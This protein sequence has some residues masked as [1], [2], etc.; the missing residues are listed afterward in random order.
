MPRMRPTR[1]DTSPRREPAQCIRELDHR[2]VPHRGPVGSRRQAPP[3]PRRRAVRDGG[4]REAAAR[5]RGP[6]PRAESKGGLP[7]GAPLLRARPPADRSVRS[8]ARLGRERG[9]RAARG[10]ILPHRPGRA[11]H[12][13]CSAPGALSRRAHPRHGE[14]FRVPRAGLRRGAKAARELTEMER[15]STYAMRPSSRFA[16]CLCTLLLATTWI[17]CAAVQ[18]PGETKADAVLKADVAAALKQWELAY[19]C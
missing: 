13:A 3:R 14:P 5:D 19:G 10:E 6:Y 18:V 17:G 7:S 8:T 1:G 12:G 2:G 16:V 15:A 4:S 11:F 9:R